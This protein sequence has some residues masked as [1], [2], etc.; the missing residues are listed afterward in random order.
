MLAGGLGLAA[1][2]VAFTS[3]AAAVTHEL[4]LAPDPDVVARSF[5]QDRRRRIRIAERPGLK[6][7]WAE[8]E[9]DLTDAFFGLH[10]ETR[11]RLGVPTQPKRFFRL[12]WSRIIEPG[13]ASFCAGR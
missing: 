9:R 13:E 11:R 4:Q 10:V 12:L 6:I 2:L 3:A 1:L 5:S 7:R 8:D